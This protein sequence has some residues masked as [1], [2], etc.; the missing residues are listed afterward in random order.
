MAS[1]LLHAK[2]MAAL[3]RYVTPDTLLAFDL[4]GTLAV[5]VDDFSAAQ[6]TEPVRSTVQRLVKHMKVTLITGRSRKDA[7][8]I[9]GFEPHLV[10]G[11]HGAE[12]PGDSDPR[13]LSFIQTCT[14]W[15]NQLDAMLK[16]A[17]GIEIEFKGASLTIHYRRAIGEDKALLLIDAAIGKL[18]PHPKRMGG[19]YVINLLPPEAPGKGEALVAALDRF[20]LKRA[21]YFGDDV[22]DEE[23]FK[24]KSLDVLGIHIGKNDRT[25]AAYYL[26]RQSELPELLNAMIG[27]LEFRLI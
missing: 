26:N 16:I 12:W 22:T 4:D 24:L 23:V 18:V 20:G 8:V 27:M 15:R 19:K 5:I 21:I 7:L 2:G 3:T 17:Q 13:N 9:L 10:I 25:A 1:Y 11:N 14:A 6:V